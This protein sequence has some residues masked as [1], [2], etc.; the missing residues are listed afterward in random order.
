[1]AG[2]GEKKSA[3]SA[4]QV[5]THNWYPHNEDPL[6]YHWIGSQ[7]K[8]DFITICMR[9]KIKLVSIQNPCGQRET[10][11][12]TCSGFKEE[13]KKK[14][15]LVIA[16]K[17]QFKM[18]LHKN[19]VYLINNSNPQKLL[20]GWEKKKTPVDFLYIFFDHF[21]LVMN[22]I[23]DFF[24]PPFEIPPTWKKNLFFYF[25]LSSYC[26]L[27]FVSIYF[28]WVL[29]CFDTHKDKKT[30]VMRSKRLC[31]NLYIGFFSWINSFCS[32]K[33]NLKRLRDF[34]FKARKKLKWKF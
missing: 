34:F 6:L 28:L 20:L 32:I 17:R 3:W 24:I 31:L 8:W 30:E 5:V 11:T 15:K 10:L 12:C 14:I 1:M 2:N 4:S 18:K 9:S 19:L 29:H 25:I 22:I 21:W 26:N 23:K 27:K 33:T 13:R 16:D 7:T